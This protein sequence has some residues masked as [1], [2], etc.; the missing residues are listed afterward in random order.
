MRLHAIERKILAGF[1]LALVVSLVVSWMLYQGVSEIISTRQWIKRADEVLGE[2]SELKHYLTQVESDVRGYVITGGHHPLDR[3]DKAKEQ[4]AAKLDTV[5]QL[6][7]DKASQQ[8]RIAALRDSVTSWV[9]LIERII[10][11]RRTEGFEPAKV[12]IDQRISEESLQGSRNILSQMESE[13]R[14]LLNSRDNADARSI[15]RMAVTTGIAFVIQLALLTLLYWLTH[16]DILERRRAEAALQ[17]VGADLAAARD[18]AL[19]A[20]KFKSQFLANMSH[21]IRTPMNGVLGMTEILLN[22]DLAPRQREFAE[23]IQSSANA[24]L[25][26]IDDILD[27]SKIEAGM[28]RFENISFNLH[29]TVENVVD[30][31]ALQAR[32]KE[33]E[34]AFLIEG[35]VPFSVTGDPIRLRQILTNLLSN[36]IKF[37]E[38]GE[39]VLRCRK[40]PDDDDGINV[41]FEISDTGIGISHDDQQLLFTPFAQADGSTTRRFGGTGLGLAISKELVTGMG[42]EIGV[43]S[44]E[45]HGSTFWFTAKFGLAQ[46]SAAVLTAKGDLR[47]ARVLLVDDNATNRKILHY[48]VT[49]W[50][51]RDSM[52]SSGP[53]ALTALRRAVAC[54]DPFAVVILDMHMPEMD[55]LRVV[56]L[57]RIDSAISQVKLVLLTSAELPDSKEAMRQE[58]DAFVTKP[59]KQSRL[60]ETLCTVLGVEAP[61]S[62]IH[63]PKQ[64]LEPAQAMGKQLRVLLAEDNEINQRVALYRLRMLEHHV[65]LAINGVEALKLLDQREYDVVLMDI[66]MPDLDGYATTAEIRRREGNRRH[67]WIIAM[68]A[69]ALPEDRE[70]CLSAGMDDY[71]AKPV[72]AP[73]LVRALEKCISH[74]GPE[75]PATNLQVLVDLGVSDILPEL[76]KTFLETA[77]Q[78]I[79]RA[80]AALHNSHAAQLAEAAHALKGSCGNLGALRLGELCQQLE[81]IGRSGSLEN[82]SAILASVQKEFARV[83]I[84]LL[85]HLDRA[86]PSQRI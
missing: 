1:L 14:G 39:V 19:S 70:K 50:G 20:A 47:N 10:D 65:D 12:L 40:L 74:A 81:T 52:A 82:A 24:L 16:V 83:Q 13:E 80:D 56:E 68:T 27:F 6:T 57:I 46:E 38:K 60:F 75:T 78:T 72:Q 49:A 4:I 34:L 30:L 54:Q 79:A 51:M 2:I 15:Q 31:F 73:A 21:E 36:S 48:Q 26:I 9:A 64:E 23:T 77:L 67:T 32:K 43:E 71:L 85:A 25:T 3:A 45:G 58:I 69:N 5:Q 8:A 61:E 37:T 29:T 22:T 53:A 42:G 55:G 66:H 76:I 84:E 17:K 28:L 41:R 62:A 18:V 44:S 63:P 33:L 35:E 11:V 86:E 7:S 59:V